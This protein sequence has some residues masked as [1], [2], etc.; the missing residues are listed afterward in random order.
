MT[1]KGKAAMN[2]NSAAL[3]ALL[4][5]SASLL[6]PRDAN[7]LLAVYSSDGATAGSSVRECPSQGVDLATGKVVVGLLGLSDA[8]RAA[9]GWYR[10]ADAAPGAG[11]R[12]TN[13]VFS[14]DGTCRRLWAERKAPARPARYSKLAIVR[15][16]KA[17]DAGDGA[18]KWDALKA[19]MDAL[20]ILDEW[21]VCTWIAGDDPA[22]VAAKPQLAAFLGMTEAALDE[23]LGECLY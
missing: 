13:V 10:V 7:A 21:S 4:L 23:M 16:L 18:T 17:M 6:A 1:T 14:A 5:A 22:F 20:G 3:S 12:A 19:K 11:W 8:R 2:R 15:A 9:C